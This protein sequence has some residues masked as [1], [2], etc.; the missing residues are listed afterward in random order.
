MSYLRNLWFRF[1]PRRAVRAVRYGPEIL[2]A[3]WVDLPAT[4]REIISRR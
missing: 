2:F 1:R 4:F 3:G